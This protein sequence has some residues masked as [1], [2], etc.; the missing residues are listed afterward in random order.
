LDDFIIFKGSIAPSPDSF[1]CRLRQYRGLKLTG[2]GVADKSVV[3]FPFS[4]SLKLKEVEGVQRNKLNTAGD[5]SENSEKKT[6]YLFIGANRIASAYKCNWEFIFYLFNFYFT[7][8]IFLLSSSVLSFLG[9]YFVT[10]KQT[11]LE[12]KRNLL[13]RTF[14]KSNGVDMMYKN[15]FL[16][17]QYLSLQIVRK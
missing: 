2:F 12:L 14:K 10:T 15:T 5:D 13:R 3:F 4:L 6:V 1:F 11:H 9:C 8:N 17:A 7:S 16:V